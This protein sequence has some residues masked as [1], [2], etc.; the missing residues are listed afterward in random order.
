MEKLLK[1]AIKQDNFNDYHKIGGY[2][3]KYYPDFTSKACK[4]SWKKNWILN[5]L[6]ISELSDLSVAFERNHTKVILLKGIYLIQ[7]LYRDFGSRF[8]SDIDILV[9]KEDLHLAQKAITEHGFELINQEKWFADDFKYIYSKK[10]GEVEIT[11][12]VHTHL[13]WD[14]DRLPESQKITNSPYYSLTLEEN[15]VHLCGH[16]AFSHTFTKI[17]WLCDIYEFYKKY[18]TDLDW[19]LVHSIAVKD[20]KLNSVIQCLFILQDSCEIELKDDLINLFKIYKNY[21]WKKLLTTD[22]LVSDDHSD[23]NFLILKQLSKDH[24]RDNIKY[25]LGWIYNSVKNKFFSK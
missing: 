14:T 3:E 9:T 24:L 25:N 13:Y 7:S 12:E 5:Q 20:S 17:Y 11:L 2:I 8:M 6:Y 10:I 19:H 23:K 15:L 4:A 21:M 16:F 1:K 22:Q 18:N